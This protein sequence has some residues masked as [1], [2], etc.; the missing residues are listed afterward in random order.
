VKNDPYCIRL[1]QLTL[2]SSTLRP[3]SHPIQWKNPAAQLGSR[4][5]KIRNDRKRP[6]EK[7]RKK[8]KMT[9]IMTGSSSSSPRR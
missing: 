9:R 8:Q 5:Q 2:I 3:K 7:G 1:S 6:E 4:A